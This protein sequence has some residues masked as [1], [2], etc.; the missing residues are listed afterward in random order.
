M[1]SS[2]NALGKSIAIMAR[3]R[4]PDGCPWDRAQTLDSI[5]PYTLEETYE[6]FDAI[7]RRSWSDLKDELGRS[8]FTG[9]FLRTDRSR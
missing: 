3:L 2:D 9:T 7:D 1:S 6:V 4:G 5:K 8:S